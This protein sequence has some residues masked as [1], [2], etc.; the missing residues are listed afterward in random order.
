MDDR[1]FEELVADALDEIPP[2]LAR[3]MSN[4]H[5]RRARISSASTRGSR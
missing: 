4:G 2:E 1:E 3:E 5:T